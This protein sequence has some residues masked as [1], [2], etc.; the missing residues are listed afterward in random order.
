VELF[1][2]MK[3]DIIRQVQNRL[4]MARFEAVFTLAK[5]SGTMPATTTRDRDTLVLALATLGGATKIETILSV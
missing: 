1:R 2:I 5:I 4:R 3:R